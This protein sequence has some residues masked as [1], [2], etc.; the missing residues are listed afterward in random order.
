MEAAAGREGQAARKGLKKT[1]PI[2][3]PCQDMERGRC[4]T[5]KQCYLA[6]DQ[7]LIADFSERRWRG[8]HGNA[9]AGRAGGPSTDVL[10][11]HRLYGCGL[12][13]LGP[14]A[15]TALWRRRAA[16][17]RVWA[18][19]RSLALRARSSGGNGL[20]GLRCARALAIHSA[21]VVVRAALAMASTRFREEFSPLR[22]C[23]PV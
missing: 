12:I 8:S 2:T 1:A 23:L 10:T 14:G 9:C 21:A 6:M 7:L 20:A 3:E 5:D 15:A 17:A 11:E 22:V 18:L 4:R 13:K 19:L 16:R